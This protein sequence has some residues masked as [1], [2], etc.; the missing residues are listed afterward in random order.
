MD[1]EHDSTQRDEDRGLSRRGLAATIALF[2]LLALFT[3]FFFAAPGT[4]KRTPAML[5]GLLLVAGV[6][7]YRVGVGLERIRLAVKNRE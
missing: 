5:F 2:V 7:F 1:K 4:G 3:V 6:G